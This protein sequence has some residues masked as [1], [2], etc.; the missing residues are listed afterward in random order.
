MKGMIGIIAAV[1]V[2]GAVAL[3]AISGNK[4]NGEMADMNMS[5]DTSQDSSQDSNMQASPSEN[6][7]FIQNF[8]FGPE[9]LIIKKG[10]TVKWTNKDDA[11]HD[12]TPDNPSESFKASELLAQGESYEFTFNTVG[13]YSYNCS[14]HPY[15]KAMVEVTE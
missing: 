6:E 11:R 14:P 8:A 15:M 12:I 7:V 4:D 13:T 9:K 1:I 2:V 10:T 5:Q 3:F